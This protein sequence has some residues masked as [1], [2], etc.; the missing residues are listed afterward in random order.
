MSPPLLRLCY[1]RR[2]RSAS[3]NLMLAIRSP[4]GIPCPHGNTVCITPRGV[5][6]DPTRGASLYSGA[7]SACGDLDIHGPRLPGAGQHVA[8]TAEPDFPEFFPPPIERSAPASTSE[9][10]AGAAP[11]RRS[12]GPPG[13]YPDLAPR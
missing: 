4:Y 12:T 3:E 2:N 9:S 8:G 1:L 7:G 11:S 13:P 10:S 5:G 6:T